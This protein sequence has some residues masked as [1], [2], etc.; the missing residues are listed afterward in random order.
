ML[1][2]IFSTALGNMVKM[3][4]IYQYA[5]Y[6]CFYV[7]FLFVKVLSNLGIS[8][9]DVRDEQMISFHFFFNSQAFPILLSSFSEV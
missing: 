9:C 6:S 2:F 7:D 3:E 8:S 5:I 1:I 4:K